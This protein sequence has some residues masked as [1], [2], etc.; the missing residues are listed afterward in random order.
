MIE[1]PQTGSVVRI[2]T[3]RPANFRGIVRIGAR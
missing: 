2:T 3:V 1:A